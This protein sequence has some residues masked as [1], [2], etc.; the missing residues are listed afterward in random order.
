MRLG[1]CVAVAQAR[2]CSSDATRSLGTSIYADEREGREERKGGREGGRQGGKE[3][4][5]RPKP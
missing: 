4:R 1:Y 3:E 5:N 2:S